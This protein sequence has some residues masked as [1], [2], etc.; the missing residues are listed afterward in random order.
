MSASFLD[1]SGRI[2]SREVARASPTRD[3][4]R[5]LATALAQGIAR[6]TTWLRRPDEE[7]PPNAHHRRD[8]GL[9]TDAKPVSPFWFDVGTRWPL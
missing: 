3:A 4:A 9:P 2:R 8:I 5:P 6:V 7:T 1:I